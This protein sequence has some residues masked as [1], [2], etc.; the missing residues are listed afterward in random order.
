LVAS[1]PKAGDYFRG[2]EGS[3]LW[4]DDFELIY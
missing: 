1:A 4:L 2:G 3:T